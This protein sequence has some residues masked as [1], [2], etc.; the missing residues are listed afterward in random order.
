MIKTLRKTKDQL[1]ARL[2][3]KHPKLFKDWVE[4]SRFLEFND[5]P[6][7]PLTKPVKECKLAFITTGGIHTIDQKPFDMT[8]PDGDPTFREIP[9]D[10]LESDLRITHNYYDH[11]D[12][13]KDVN[14]VLPVGRLAELKKAVEIYP[15]FKEAQDNLEVLMNIMGLAPE[16]SMQ[17]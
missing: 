2:L 15:K 12:A 4:K 9:A 13:D 6:W 5:S 3:V 11:R 14:I 10:V 1:I 7:T 17:S 16:S 8:D